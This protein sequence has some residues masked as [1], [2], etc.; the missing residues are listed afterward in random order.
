M[1]PFLEY[2]WQP[3]V[4]AVEGA[5]KAILAGKVEVYDLDRDPAEASDLGSGANLPRRCG[6][7]LEDYPVPSPE[8]ARAAGHAGRR[9]EAAAGQPGLRQRRRRT[10]RPQG[11]AAAGRHDARCSAISSARRR[12]SPA[13]STPRRSRCSSGSSRADPHNLDAALRLATAHSSLGHDALA[14]AAFKKAAA[15]GAALAGRADLPRAALRARQGLG[16]AAPLL[17]QVVAESPDRLPALEALAVVRE[18]QGR[19]GRGGGPA[20]ADLPPAHAVGRRAGAART[21]GDERA[22]DAAGDRGVRGGA[23]ASPGRAFTHDLELG[24]LYLAA[25][26]LQD[27]RDGARPRPGVVARYP[28]ALFKRAQVSVLLHE[29]DQ[30]ARIDAA[31][32]HAD[33]TTRPLI[34]RER[35]FEGK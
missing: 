20:S 30:A 14:V 16:A 26:R 13:A 18:R 6:R 23:R 7:A 24:V 2:G 27:A 9:G 8:A 28:M 17:E 29:P 32:R 21:A 25:R 4:M 19:R 15:L 10:G 22:A 5:R 35:L 12:S 33:A 31:R 34:A 11:R 3:Q 1:K